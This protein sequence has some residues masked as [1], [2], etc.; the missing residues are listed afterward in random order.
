MSNAVCHWKQD[1]IGGDSSWETD[2]GHAFEFNDG[3]PA[4]N[5]QKFCGY[6]ARPL[7]EVRTSDDAEAR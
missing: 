6:C 3:G 7:V 5:G 4:D 1:D 2:C